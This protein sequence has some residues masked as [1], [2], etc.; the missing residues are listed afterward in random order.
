MQKNENNAAECGKGV[1]AWIEYRL[2]VC[3]FFRELANYQ[4]PKNLNYAW[5]FGSLAGIALIIQVITGIFLAMHYTPHVDHAFNSVERIMRD[6][7]YGWLV[8]YTH[9]VGASFFLL[10]FIYTFSEG[11]IMGHIRN[12]GSWYGLR[13]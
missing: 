6:V 10:L 2:P 5:N 1:L 12:L 4:V 7:H 8:R 9:A 13:G 3:A 11:S